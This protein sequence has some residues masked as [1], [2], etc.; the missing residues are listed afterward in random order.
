M[1]SIARY[2]AIDLLR[3]EKRGPTLVPDVPE[4]A[5][6]EPDSQVESPVS[7]SGA[8]LLERCVGLLT[9]PQKQCLELAFVGGSSHEDIAR[10]TGN[11]CPASLRAVAAGL[12]CGR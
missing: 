11:P 8:P 9:P 5:E 2:R 4:R 10:L 7:I 1:M 12:S 3:H 6:V